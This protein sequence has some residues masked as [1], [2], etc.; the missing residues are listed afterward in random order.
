MR[1]VFGYSL[2]IAKDNDQSSGNHYRFLHLINELKLRGCVGKPSFQFPSLGL[3][4]ALIQTQVQAL[5]AAS[6][7]Y[8]K[9]KQTSG[10]VAQ[11]SPSDVLEVI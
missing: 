5:S 7:D 1:P 6:R 4:C 10:Q 9:Y 2:S 3:M 11:L 8:K